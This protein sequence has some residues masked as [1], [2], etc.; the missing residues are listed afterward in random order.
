MIKY[1]TLALA[2]G[3]ATGNLVEPSVWPQP[4]ESSFGSSPISISPTVQFLG[5][6][7]VGTLSAAYERYRKIMFPHPVSASAIAAA[8]EVVNVKVADLSEAYP[9]LETD[10]SYQL[11][12]SEAGEVTISANT[13]YG[14]I[15]GLETLSQLVVFDFDS[16]SYSIIAAPVTISDS[17]RYKHRG[18]LMDTSRHFQPIPNLQRLIDAM[19]YTKMNGLCFY[20]LIGCL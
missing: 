1:L 4:K 19:S 20:I 8:A 17:P 3:C 13:V 18:I 2:A 14:A 15:Y 10:E 11:T 7:D 9:Q 6:N 12:V 16:R 5:G